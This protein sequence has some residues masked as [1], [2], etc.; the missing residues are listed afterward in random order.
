MFS[1]MFEHHIYSITKAKGYI[2]VT[3]EYKDKK[4]VCHPNPSQ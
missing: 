2:G 4:M 3:F 1:L